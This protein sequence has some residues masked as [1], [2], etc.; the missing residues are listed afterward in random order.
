[1]AA[2]LSS[3]P[4][5]E[6]PTVAL[7]L[8]GGGALGAY[9]IGAYQA[10]AEHNLHPDWVAGISIGAINSAIIAGNRSEDR[11][12]RLAALW[13][14]ISRPELPTKLAFPAWA[15]WQNIAS[16]AEALLFG[17]PNFLTPRPV[18]VSGAARGTKRGQLIRHS[19][20]LGGPKH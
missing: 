14:A 16:N 13:E 10:L 18:P 7:M 19:A 12:E 17:Q 2:R 1:M 3:S 5:R 20:R 11:V 15:T 9:H 4:S 6:K 8:Q